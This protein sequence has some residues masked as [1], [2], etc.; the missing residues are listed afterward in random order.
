MEGQE[1][2]KRVRITLDEDDKGSCRVRV[3][4]TGHGIAP[5][6]LKSIFERGFS[7][8]S[9]RSGG[10][11]LHWCGNAAQSLGGSLTASDGPGTGAT[12]VLELESTQA[13]IKEAA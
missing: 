12:F 10:L 8:R 1:G 7:T 3:S 4:D 2:P 11:G 9:R 13:A 6:H 5:D